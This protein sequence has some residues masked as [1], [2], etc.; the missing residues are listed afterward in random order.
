MPNPFVG[1]MPDGGA[2]NTA[3]TIQRREL[4]R[5]YPQFGTINEQLVPI[6]TRDYQAIQI[7]W[8]KRLSQGVHMSV[9]Y[10]GSRNVE[11]TAPLNQ[12]EP[13]YEEVTNTHRPHVL[14]LTGGWQL[15]AFEGRGTLARLLLGGWQINA[16]TFFRSGLN[17]PMPGLVDVIGDPVLD[18]PTTA[19]WFNTCTLTAAG[20]RQGCASES[21]QPAFRIRPENAL[22]TTGA[23]LE[24]VYR[25]EPI[26]VDMSFFKTIRLHGRQNFQV[27][28]EMF[29]ALNK[30]QWPQPEHDHHRGAV[31]PGHR[32]PAERSALHP[33]RLQG[34]RSRASSSEP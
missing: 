18:N 22:D 1:L 21:E 23:R 17:V 26:N 34:T 33:A 8:D 28:V 7:S 31:R 3:A 2:R 16:T 25:S 24:G 12:G 10:T 13:L 29:N 15:P 14:R 6:G 27:R 11:R 9:A 32:D 20:A 19:R 4:M 30:V 5:P